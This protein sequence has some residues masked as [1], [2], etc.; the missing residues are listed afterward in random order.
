MKKLFAVVCCFLTISL[1]TSC[2]K[3]TEKKASTNTKE[4]K[5]ENKKTDIKA[6]TKEEVGQA[7]GLF[8][9]TSV[10]KSGIELDIEALKKSYKEAMKRK[11]DSA[12]EQVAASVLNSALQIAYE[13]KKE[14]T[15][16]EGEEFLAKNAKRPEVISLESGLQYEIIKEG[17]GIQPKDGDTCKLH[18]KG[19]FIDG[20]AFE[21]SK[22]YKEGKPVE[23]DLGM[24]IPGWQ[25]GLKKMKVGGKYKLYVPYALGYGEQGI[26][27]P[28][29]GQEII[30]P[31]AA[32]IFEI[33]LIDAAPVKN[34]EKA[35]H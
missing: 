35:N 20:K 32:L 7:Y 18:Y 17:T 27:S 13:K 25:E 6:P 33:E 4:A 21:D 15:K 34:T 31:C 5:T 23:I 22:D 16:K 24:V 29:S 26:R 10:Q 8:L 2:N 3:E 30:P 19:M 9:A 28:Q 11:L 12:D 1:V 14:Q